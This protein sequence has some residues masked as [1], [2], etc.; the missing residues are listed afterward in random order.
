VHVF[1]K[2][3]TLNRSLFGSPSAHRALLAARYR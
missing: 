3:A 1:L 2:R